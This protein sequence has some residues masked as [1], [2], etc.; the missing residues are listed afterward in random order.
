M[1]KRRNNGLIIEDGMVTC[2]NISIKEVIIPYGVTSIADN[3][4]SNCTKLFPTL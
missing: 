2:K 1:E 4:F 3:A